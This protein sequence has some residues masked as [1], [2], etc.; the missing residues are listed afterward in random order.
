MIKG[1]HGRLEPDKKRIFVKGSYRTGSVKK[2]RVITRV[3]TFYVDLCL[4]NCEKVIIII[5]RV[6]ILAEFILRV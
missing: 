6:V 5:G 1:L 3:I 2:W 4:R